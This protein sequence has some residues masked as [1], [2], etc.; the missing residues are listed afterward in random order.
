MFFIDVGAVLLQEIFIPGIDAAFRLHFHLAVSPDAPAMELSIG[1]ICLLVLERAVDEHIVI[2]RKRRVVDIFQEQP[3]QIGRNLI[4][5][6][7]RI[8]RAAQGKCCLRIRK[9]G[10]LLVCRFGRFVRIIP[11]AISL[12]IGRR[13]TGKPQ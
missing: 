7:L 11:R 8:N 12:R 10:R 4:A 13:T 6:R 3:K 9:C 1:K 5:C 2:Q